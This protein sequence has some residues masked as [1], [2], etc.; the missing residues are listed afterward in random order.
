MLV[1]IYRLKW[2]ADNESVKKSRK[3]MDYFQWAVQYFVA[4]YQMIIYRYPHQYAIHNQISKKIYM[5]CF[6]RTQ[7]CNVDRWLI[8]DD[9]SC[10]LVF[11]GGS[12]HLLNRTEKKMTSDA[13]FHAYKT[14][15]TTTVLFAFSV[16]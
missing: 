10:T 6:L 14:D 8:A 1:Y 4:C 13:A 12:E 7:C 2:F 9:E 5:L 3:K 15:M 16:P 11:N